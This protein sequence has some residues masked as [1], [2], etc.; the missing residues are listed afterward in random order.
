[1]N[2]ITPCLW[3]ADDAEEAAKFYVSLLPNS[4]ITHVMRSPTDYP[5]GKAGK[6]LLV[7]FTLA[8]QPYSALNGGEKLEYNNAVSFMI[9]CAD[10]AEVDRLWSALAD[11]GT[12]MQ[13][14]WIKDRWG[15]PWQVVP[16]ALMRMMRD[17]D[18]ARVQRVFQAMMT[19]VKVDI[20]KLQAAYDGK[21]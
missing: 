6:V 4:Q 11:G 12:E 2:K 7:E 20:A 13:C 8:G 18:S 19:M 5:G 14:G 15:I 21:A 16:N 10:Q 9:D 17:P 1:M 3:Y